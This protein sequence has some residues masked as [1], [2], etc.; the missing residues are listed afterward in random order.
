MLLA[1]GSD[2]ATALSTLFWNPAITRVV[3]LR[4]AHRPDQLD[5]PQISVDAGGR[6]EVGGRAIT[7]PLL[8]DDTATTITFRDAKT[9]AHWKRVTLWQPNGPARM[10]SVVVYRLSSSQL[11]PLGWLG[12][13]E[14]QARL[15]GWVELRLSAPKGLRAVHLDLKRSNARGTATRYMA[16]GGRTT[17]VRIAACGRGP[18]IRTFQAGP[19][20]VRDGKLLAPMLAVPRYVP[21]ASA[22]S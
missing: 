22:C 7:S 12:L 1:P 13:W 9:L 4:G 2:P 16:A 18:W 5:D 14:P 20:A 10:S 15:E 6:I 17:V 21:D 11:L 3:R 19:E 8:V